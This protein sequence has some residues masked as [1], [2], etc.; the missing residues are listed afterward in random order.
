MPIADDLRLNAKEREM[1]RRIAEQDGITVDEAAT[2]LVRA[3]LARRVRKRTG[4]GPARV[5]SMK[6]R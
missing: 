2:R 5:Y 6:R 3:A 1:V 4:R